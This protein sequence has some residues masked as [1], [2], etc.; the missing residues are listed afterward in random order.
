MICKYSKILFDN[1]SWL[2]S[3]GINLF[4]KALSIWSLAGYRLSR[5]PEMFLKF[6]S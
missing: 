6:E 2:E 5:N 4:R 1:M 3:F